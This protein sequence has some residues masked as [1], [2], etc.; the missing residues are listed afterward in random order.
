[1][2]V[3]VFG[4]TTE[5]AELARR[6][7]RPG[8]EV[9]VSV[10]TD[11]GAELLRGRNVKVLLGRL[12]QGEMA[13]LMA[14]YDAVI[15]ATHPYAA[16]VSENIAA[17]AAQLGLPV[18]RLLRSDDGG[19]GDWIEVPDAVQAARRL[20]ALPGNILLTT[21]S[22]DLAAYT[23]LEDYR[24]RVWVRILPSQESLA[25]ALELGYP[26]RHLIAMHGPFSEELN[27]ALM[28]QLDIRVLVTKRSGSAGGFPEKVRAARQAGA[29]LLVLSRPTREQGETLE[30]ILGRFAPK[31]G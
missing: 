27:L 3:L 8:L 14:E 11:Y 28:H 4:G 22:K 2:K 7:P 13:E 25:Q 20:A 23:A 30:E 19:E 5:G 29:A 16:Q 17:A 1:M 26:P 10:A 12:N 21:G 15:D 9:A 18:Y 31:D 24:E 6:L